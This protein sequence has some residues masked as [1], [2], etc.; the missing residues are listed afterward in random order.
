M[1]CLLLYNLLQIKISMHL[2]FLLLFFKPEMLQTDDEGICEDITWLEEH[3]Q[4][5]V[6]TDAEAKL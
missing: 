6:S 2:L 4:G 3:C 5:Q 1:F